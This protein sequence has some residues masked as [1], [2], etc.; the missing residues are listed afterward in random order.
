MGMRPTPIFSKIEIDNPGAKSF[1]QIQTV[2]L[3][4]RD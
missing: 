1:N 2:R 4:E 3:H